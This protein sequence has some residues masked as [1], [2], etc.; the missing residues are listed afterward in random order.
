MEYESPKDEIKTNYKGLVKAN[1]HL[2]KIIGKTERGCQKEI[3]KLQ[4]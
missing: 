1:K 4:N 2:L 3:T